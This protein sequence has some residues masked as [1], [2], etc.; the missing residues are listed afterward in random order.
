MCI[1]VIFAPPGDY[2]NTGTTIHVK[3]RVYLLHMCLRP[4]VLK[5]FLV[6]SSEA[7][8][9][10]TLL[11][12]SVFAF[13][14]V[15]SSLL[16]NCAKKEPHE[17]TRPAPRFGNKVSCGMT[18]CRLLRPMPSINIHLPAE[19]HGSDNAG[20]FRAPSGAGASR[21][22]LDWRKLATLSRGRYR[23]QRLQPC[24]YAIRLSSSSSKRHVRRVAGRP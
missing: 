10:Q 21:L 3:V 5:T 23:E 13:L 22:T 18:R 17:Q 14:G 7:S 6:G 16:F 19:Q 20:R 1:T 8:V 15:L 24:C 9:N 4:G 2:L 11:W 12:L